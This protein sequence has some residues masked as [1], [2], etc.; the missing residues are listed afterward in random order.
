MS[1]TIFSEAGKSVSLE[2]EIRA[3]QHQAGSL[4]QSWEENPGFLA[5]YSYQEWLPFPKR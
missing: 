2:T 1:F 5:S 4:E 3:I